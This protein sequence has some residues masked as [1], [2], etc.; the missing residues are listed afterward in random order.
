MAYEDTNCPCGDKKERETMLCELCMDHLKDR[1][2]MQTWQDRE[3]RWDFRRHAAIILLTLARRRKNNLA[4]GNRS[5]VPATASVSR[6]ES[7]T[8]LGIASLPTTPADAFSCASEP[9]HAGAGVSYLAE[10]SV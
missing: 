5:P 8:R 4:L 6:P 3:E 9:A 2:E 1:H 10:V 7:A